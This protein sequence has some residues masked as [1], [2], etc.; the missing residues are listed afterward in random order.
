MENPFILIV[1]LPILLELLVLII[2]L[3]FSFFSFFSLFSLFSLNFD[4]A[5]K[6]LKNPIVFI[7]LTKV[8]NDLKEMYLYL[9]EI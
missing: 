7:I 9:L 4:S 1:L 3:S 5:F 8:F 2:N 6:K